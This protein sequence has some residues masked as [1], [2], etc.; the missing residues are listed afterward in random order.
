MHYAH[1]HTYRALAGSL[2]GLKGRRTRYVQ[3]AHLYDSWL[4]S[5]RTIKVLYDPLGI[6]KLYVEH[7]RSILECVFVVMDE[8]ASC[9]LAMYISSFIAL[10]IVV[11][12]LGFVF[13]T[14][15]DFRREPDGCKNLDCSPVTLDPF[16]VNLQEYEDRLDRGPQC[17]LCEPEPSAL[18]FSLERFCCVVFTIEYCLRLLTCSFIQSKGEIDQGMLNTDPAFEYSRFK[19][20]RRTMHFVFDLMNIIDLLAIGPCWIP[21]NVNLPSTTFLRV[22]RLARVIKLIK[23]F[24]SSPRFQLFG[25]GMIVILQVVNQSA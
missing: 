19:R 17:K 20:V 5:A 3:K 22:L 2:E 10:V 12:V 21:K 23:V 8:P 14:V 16:N 9:R 4:P 18:F 24:A 25:D 15:P 11:S 13:E 1:T 6:P 7:H